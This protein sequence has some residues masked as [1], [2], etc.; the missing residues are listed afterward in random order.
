MRRVVGDLGERRPCPWRRA[1][2]GRSCR[3]SRR[4]PGRRNGRPSASAPRPRR[5]SATPCP[6]TVGGASSGSRCCCPTRPA[7]RDGHRACAELSSRRARRRRV[8]ADWAVSET[9]I[10]EPAAN[11]TAT[12]TARRCLMRRSVAQAGRQSRGV[13]A[14]GPAVVHPPPG[15]ELQKRSPGRARLRR[16]EEAMERRHLACVQRELACERRRSGAERRVEAA[17]AMLPSLPEARRRG[18][19][20]RRRRG[21]MSRRFWIAG[22]GRH[23]L[24]RRVRPPVR[25]H[26][27]FSAEFDANAPVTLRGPVTKVE[28]INP[29]AWIHMEVKTPKAR[30][31]PGWWKAARRTRCSAAASRATRSKSAPSSS[32]PA[33]RPRTAG[34]GPTAATSH[35]PTAARS[36]WDRRAP[37]RRKMAATRTKR[38]PKKPGQLT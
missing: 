32:S 31:R 30:R 37:A 35:F 9:T 34:C 27:A 5:R 28:W 6:S 21:A 2:A 33:T 7:D 19:P 12:R 4:R 11:A 3:R 14:R 10:S 15:R 22:R 38:P 1:S 17:N 23:V 24:A 29:H 16:D 26:H 18:A 36:S 8:P 25:A 13:L 20:A